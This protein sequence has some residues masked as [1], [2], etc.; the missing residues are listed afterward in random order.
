[1][2]LEQ[3]KALQGSLK[4]CS[5][6][7]AHHY[8]GQNASC[9]WCAIE[10]RT[11]TRL[12]GYKLK[13]DLSQKSLD[14][15][16][17]W[18]AVVSIPDPPQYP[19]PNLS[20]LKI[21]KRSSA[22]RNRLRIKKVRQLG[23]TIIAAGTFLTLA[24]L[25]HPVA[26]VST[27]TLFAVMAWPRNKRADIQAATKAE[28]DAR[29]AYE[30]AERTWKAAAAGLSFKKIRQQCYE[31]KLG[32]DQLPAEQARRFADLKSEAKQRESY[33]DGFRIDK[34]KIP[35]IGPSRIAAL[36]SF[37]IETA[38]DVTPSKVQAIPGFGPAT[39]DKLL[40][41][42]KSKEVRFRFNANH[43]I[44]AAELNFIKAELNAK[45]QKF[46][47]VLRNGPHQLT[48]ASN[49]ASH[50]VKITGPILEQN[51]INWQ[52][53]KRHRDDFY[54][55][56]DGNQRQFAIISLI[57]LYIIALWWAFSIS[58][59]PPTATPIIPAAQV[60]V[61]VVSVPTTRA[62]KPNIAKPPSAPSI[63]TTNEIAPGP[64]IADN[65]IESAP[66]ASTSQN[67]LD[68]TA[69]SPSA[70]PTPERN[71]ALS[72][73]VAE[74]LNTGL[75]EPWNSDG[76]NGTVT[77]GE[78]RYYAGKNCRSFAYSSGNIISQTHYACQGTDGIWRP[79][80]SFA[81]KKQ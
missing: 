65:N 35:S 78:A 64:E 23:A 11:G 50:I 57:L 69:L 7:E 10:A 20:L 46:A 56:L 40:T 60:P 75:V 8:P 59:S 47:T 3:L 44:A 79:E 38:W 13:S 53:A 41:W 68:T 62:P 39:A 26:A 52:L 71:A 55:A 33:L 54:S 66:E 15:A 70:F 76:M 77:V 1:M 81:T 19:P 30:D 18:G 34:E 73:A 63:A 48:H 28:A 2:W 72:R 49:D 16:A 51:W 5:A 74:A 17:L 25:K 45:A 4:A 43:P 36:S 27:A 14:V 31:A 61:P 58:G 67:E 12:F 6:N 9:P 42:R 24:E 22:E 29:T 37:G 80:E 21:S 32:L